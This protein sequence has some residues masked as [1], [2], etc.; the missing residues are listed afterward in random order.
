MKKIIVISFLLIMGVCWYWYTSRP[1]YVVHQ[2]LSSLKGKDESTFDRYVEFD[3]LSESLFFQTMAEPKENDGGYLGS[4]IAVVQN[5]ILSLSYE[6][7]FKMVQEMKKMFFSEDYLPLEFPFVK[8]SIYGLRSGL[9]FVKEI[10]KEKEVVFVSFYHGEFNKKFVVKL[11][12]S[13]GKIREILNFNDLKRSYQ[14]SLLEKKVAENKRLRAFIESRLLRID[15]TRMGKDED[16]FFSYATKIIIEPKNI[17][18][19][20]IIS[21]KFIVYLNDEYD[22][23][24]VIKEIEWT[25]KIQPGSETLIEISSLD[26][27]VY[28]IFNLMKQLPKIE[29]NEIRFSDGEEY[30]MEDAI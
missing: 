2:V 27:E 17:S 24:K 18:N 21:L 9:I 26:V 30:L 29:I 14:E 13:G 28:R 5:T 3:S 11:K 15:S 19:K 1:E 20:E 7:N 8:S 6:R 10:K 16:N 23:R 4:F 12:I 22:Q 25:E